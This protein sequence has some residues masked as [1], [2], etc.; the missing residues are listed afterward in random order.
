MGHSRTWA[1]ELGCKVETLPT[2][3]LGLP[4]RGAR[5]SQLGCEI[6]L[7]KDLGGD[8]LIGSANIFLRGGGLH[9]S[10]APCLTFLF[11]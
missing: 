1:A 3:Y 8:W 4:F 10:K 11:I 9:L 7:R 6:L 2:T 5:I